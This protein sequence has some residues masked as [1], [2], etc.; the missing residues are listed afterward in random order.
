MAPSGLWDKPFSFLERPVPIFVDIHCLKNFITNL[1]N[2]IKHFF[3][4]KQNFIDIEI[5]KKLNIMATNHDN[6]DDKKKSNEEPDFSKDST[7]EFH[8]KQNLKDLNSEAFS[9]K[10]ADVANKSEDDEDVE[11]KNRSVSKTSVRD[12]LPRTDTGITPEQ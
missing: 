5:I 1:E 11:Y 4:K 10:E 9:S 3:E 7:L 6:H 12:R 2:G 8:N